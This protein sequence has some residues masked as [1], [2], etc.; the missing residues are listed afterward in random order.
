MDKIKWGILGTGT[1]AHKFAHAIVNVPAAELLAVASR[2]QETADAFQKEF[3]IPLSYHSYQALAEDPEIDAVYIAVPHAQHHPCAKLCMEAG[4]HVLCEKP[5]AI[6]QAQFLDVMQT[7]SRC[8][9]FFMEALWTRFLPAVRQAITMSQSGAIGRIMGV[10][11]DF[12]YATP[13]QSRSH[14]V[15]QNANGG[16]ALLDVGVYV[17]NWAAMF[18]GTCPESIQAVSQI[19]PS[20]VDEYTA[21][22]LTYSSG[23]IAD[24]SCGIVLPKR[25]DGYVYGENGYLHLPDFYTASCL[26]LCQGNETKHYSLPY[27]GNGFEEEIEECCNCILEGKKESDIMPLSETLAITKLMDQVRRIIGLSYPADINQN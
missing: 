2:K 10:H 19:G 24:L 11:A 4:K 26:E 12:C 22:L 14:H 17:L 1:I 16:G 18:L 6:N 21:L 20:Q 23:A 3:S 25:N 7:A 13:P 9:V 27:A 5:A 15:F 8:N